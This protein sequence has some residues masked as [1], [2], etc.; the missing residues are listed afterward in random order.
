MLKR[1][2]ILVPF[3]IT[4]LWGVKVDELADRVKAYYAQVETIQAQF[5]E[6]ICVK[7]TGS[8]QEFQG[9]VYMK[10]PNKFRLEV[11]EPEPQ[12]LIGDGEWFWT[13]LPS[14]SLA[15]RAQWNDEYFSPLLILEDY[16]ERFKVELLSES[17]TR[18]RLTPRSR[19][20]FFSE[21]EIEVDEKTGEVKVVEV[22]DVQGNETRFEL[23]EIEY[24]PPLVPEI[25]SFTPPA[26]IE[27]LEMP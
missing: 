24:N 3:L 1:F 20:E 8:C 4:G 11:K 16:G 21:I 26:G 2:M 7:A 9:V 27:V 15:Y 14:D 23:S 25:F 18:L 5:H 13:Y 22:K 19:D 10:R 6:M 17:P 12:L